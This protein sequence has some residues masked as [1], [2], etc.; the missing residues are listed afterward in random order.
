MSSAGPRILLLG[1]ARTAASGVATHLNQLFGSRLAAEF[2]FS[3]FQVGREGRNEGR[4]GGVLRLLTS[5][6]AFA[7]CVLRG[8]PQI[9]HINTSLDPKGYW[10]DVVY[11]I[12]AKALRRRVVYQIHGGALPR[13]FCARSRAL[14]GLL[15]RVLKSADAVVLLAECE[16]AA[17]REFAP[18]ARLVRIA[19]GVPPCAP[20]V[21]TERHAANQPLAIVY[22]GRLAATKGILEAVAAV[23]LLRERGVEVGLT[24][25]GS[26]A[27]LH[28]I[29]Q[30]IELARLGERVRL[31]GELFGEAKR[32]LWQQADV[33]VLPSYHEGL[34]YAL[35]ESMACGV[36]PVASPVG[37]IPDVVQDGVNGLLVAPRDPQ[38]VADALQRLATDR[39]LLHRLARAARERIEAQYSVTR[40]EG[41]FR[42][43]Y[44]SLAP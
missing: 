15:R 34:P 14:A 10:R 21:S 4:I 40:L 11:L 2:R 18:F 12:V 25:A 19:N 38:A 20:A 27:A 32:Q 42:A 9:V 29:R 37:G 23:A 13:E 43:L 41:Q 22:L 3:Q 1:P 30:A 33:F 44:R 7:A 36:V 28:E 39:E 5:P 26:G 24:I 31:A 6:V 16:I 35:L 8:R 17:Y